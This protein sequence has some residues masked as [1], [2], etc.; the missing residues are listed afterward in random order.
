MLPPGT[1]FIIAY[2]DSLPVLAGSEK[3]NN[4]SQFDSLEQDFTRQGGGGGGGGGGAFRSQRLNSEKLYTDL[5][6]WPLLVSL[7]DQR[8][9]IT[10]S[11][12][13]SKFP[14]YEII[15]AMITSV[16]IIIANSMRPTCIDSKRINYPMQNCIKF[17]FEK[18]HKPNVQ[19]CR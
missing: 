16:I 11:N 14:W 15:I 13:V 18:L 7:V 6:G 17:N 19:D 1:D 5:K 3:G 9:V 12:I 4:W 10:K 8:P 2:M